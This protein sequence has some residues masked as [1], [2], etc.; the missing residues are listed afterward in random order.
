MMI[1]QL[2]QRLLPRYT[3]RRSERIRLTLVE[4]VLHLFWPRYLRRRPDR[5]LL[6]DHKAVYFAIPKVACTSLKFMCAEAMGCQVRG[7][8]HF[9]KFPKIVDVTRGPYSD[10]FKFGFVRNP[11]D[12]VLSC[13]LHKIREDGDV[14]ELFTKEGLY[15]PFKRYGLFRA[16]MSF[17]EFVKAI[18]AIDD[19][20]A[21]VHFR[22]Q[23]R[24]I[25]EERGVILLDFVGRF[26]HLERDVTRVAK[27]LGLE[28]IRLHHLEKTDHRHYREYY[29]LKSRKRIE[30]RYKK[31][32]ELFDYSF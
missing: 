7:N 15:S 30:R 9:F 16:G 14:H 24:F 26:E 27:K 32:L 10:Y 11:F 2:L 25:S 20:E 4:F 6:E 17:E 12:R 5:I 31:D 19:D 21:D 1:L 3:T 28:E 18:S 29:G 23:H 8:V 13:Y 22:S